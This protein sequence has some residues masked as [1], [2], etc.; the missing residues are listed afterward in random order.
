M[1]KIYWSALLHRATI[2]KLRNPHLCRFVK[3]WLVNALFLT[4]CRLP[5]PFTFIHHYHIHNAPNRFYEGI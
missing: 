3:F 1:A 4:R 2:K 5:V